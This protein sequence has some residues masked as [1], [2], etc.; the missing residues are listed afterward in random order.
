VL[1]EVVATSKVRQLLSL[2][3]TNIE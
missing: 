2:I 1:R 3:I